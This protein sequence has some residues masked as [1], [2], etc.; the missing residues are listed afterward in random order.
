[1]DGVAKQSLARMIAMDIHFGDSVS[2]VSV[3][4]LKL[5][6]SLGQS[7]EAKK[8]DLALPRPPDYKTLAG[9]GL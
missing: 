6:A 9:L 4:L 7:Y 5:A 1:M 8:L 3:A 2:P